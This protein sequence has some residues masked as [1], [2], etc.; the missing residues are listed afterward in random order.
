MILK[1]NVTG[2]RK[3]KIGG[4]GEGSGSFFY[5]PIPDQDGAFTMSTRIELDPGSSIGYHEHSDNE[6]VY[7]IMSGSGL[8]T[9][10]GEKMDV[11]AGDLLLCRTGHSHGIKNT[12]KDKMIIGAAIAKRTK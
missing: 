1:N 2:I 6:E 10:E 9:E 4:S 7:F 5:I 11:Q 8:Y 3:N 12:G